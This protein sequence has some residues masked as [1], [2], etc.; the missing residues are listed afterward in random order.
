MTFKLCTIWPIDKIQSGST[1]LPFW[2]WLDLGAW[3]WRGTLHFLMFQH[4]WSLIM[5]LFSV[6]FRTLVGGVLTFC[7]CSRYIQQ[8]QLTRPKSWGRGTNTI[9]EAQWEVLRGKKNYLRSVCV[10]STFLPKAGYNDFLSIC[11]AFNKFPDFFV[12][13]FKIVIDSWKFT[14]L[15][16]YI[17]W[18]DWPIFMISGS[19]EQ[20][21]Q[22]FEYTLLKPD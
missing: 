13:A 7:R 9:L 17:L 14:M 12:Q 18:D 8:T 10:Y 5:E 16:L 22:E 15:L 4:Y 3:Q 21:Q 11:G 1:I 20:L 2:T 6:T 19:N